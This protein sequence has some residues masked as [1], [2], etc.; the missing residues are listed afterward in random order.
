VTKESS[1]SSAREVTIQR[2]LENLTSI[3]LSYKEEPLRWAAS[4]SCCTWCQRL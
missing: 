4:H 2:D 3:S 1:E